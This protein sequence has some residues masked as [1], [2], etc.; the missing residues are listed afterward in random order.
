MVSST[1][2]WQWIDRLGTFLSI[3]FVLTCLFI[4]A[5]GRSI[6]PWAPFVCLAFGVGLVIASPGIMVSGRTG[7]T[8]RKRIGL[9]L[10]FCFGSICTFFGAR[11]F[12]G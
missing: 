1:R 6:S 2:I 5:T 9:I 4:T 12:W 10:V 11:Y 3:L 8:Q 7:T